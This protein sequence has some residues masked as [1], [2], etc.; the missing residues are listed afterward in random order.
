MAE[1]AVLAVMSESS[2]TK[3]SDVRVPA[4]ADTRAA[5]KILA[6][7]PA[8][9]AA[10]DLSDPTRPPRPPPFPVGAVVRYDGT[11]RVYHDS[12]QQAPILVPG[13][14]VSIES[15][16]PGSR[17]TGEVLQDAVDRE[18]VVDRTRDG[19]SVY[20]TTRGSPRCIWA[21]AEDWTLVRAPAGPGEIDHRVGDVV[22]E[23][24]VF[25]GLVFEAGARRI[26]VVWQSGQVTRH[27]QGYLGFRRATPEVWSGSGDGA[28]DAANEAQTRA[29]LAEELRRVHA[30]RGVAAHR[31]SPLRPRASGSPATRSAAR[32]ER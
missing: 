17:G 32:V 5:A 31:T 2:M 18:G 3:R 13:M 20:R 26:S 21:G 8:S 14:I 10:M 28:V 22:V 23:H 30:E 24:G 9:L 6:E 29:Q 12:A 25:F 1:K 16:H 7:T 27:V 15:V 4:T 19:R 11:R